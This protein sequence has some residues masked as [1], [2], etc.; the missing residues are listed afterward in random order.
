MSAPGRWRPPLGELAV[1]HLEHAVSHM[2][3]A[4][5]VRDGHDGLDP[6]LELGNE[7]LIGAARG[8]DHAV[9]L[10]KLEVPGDTATGVIQAME[11]IEQ[12]RVAKDGR[13]ELAIASRIAAWVGW[14]S[15]RT[16]PLLGVY[17]PVSSLA[18][19][20]LAAAIAADHEQDFTAQA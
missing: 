14:P 11:T 12:V 16:S 7:P 20:G 6:G 9:E 17:R 19:V 5:V 2:P 15:S 1:R 10:E 8:A 4:I 18:R 3:V 13:K